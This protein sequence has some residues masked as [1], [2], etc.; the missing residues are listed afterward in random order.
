MGNGFTGRSIPK[1]SGK[2]RGI[3]KTRLMSELCQRAELK[4][5]HYGVMPLPHGQPSHG[6][7]GRGLTCQQAQP[8]VGLRTST[9]CPSSPKSPMTPSECSFC[10]TSLH[11]DLGG[12][13]QPRSRTAAFQP[14]PRD[15]GPRP[16]PLPGASH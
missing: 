4:P 10:P 3:L 2:V 13:R 15:P 9:H 6:G 11:R 1:G 8:A 12:S 5:P 7:A 14:H 16:P